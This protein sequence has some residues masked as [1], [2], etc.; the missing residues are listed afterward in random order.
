LTQQGWRFAFL[1][2]ERDDHAEGSSRKRFPL[3]LAQGS[4]DFGTVTLTFARYPCTAFCCETIESCLEKPGLR[5]RKT[6]SSLHAWGSGS[7][8]PQL[9][10]IEAGRQG[11]GGWGAARSLVNKCAARSAVAMLHHA[12]AVNV[13]A[14]YPPRLNKRRSRSS[15]PLATSHGT[16]CAGTS[17]VFSGSR[18]TDFLIPSTPVLKP[19]PGPQGRGL[20][21]WLAGTNRPGNERRNVSTRAGSGLGFV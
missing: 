20:I 15:I 14:T 10:L 11:V 19:R 4:G 6:P 8:L 2:F 16:I 12:A 3:S 7:L 9:R 13:A 18:K 17:F 1:H 21:L 5:Q